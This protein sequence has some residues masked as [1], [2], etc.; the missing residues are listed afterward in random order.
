MAQHTEKLADL[1][2]MGDFDAVVCSHVLE[3]IPQPERAVRQFLPLSDWF[4]IEVPLENTYGLLF[5]SRLPI[6]HQE[7][8]Y[9]VDDET[10]S[11]IADLSFSDATVRIYGVHPAPPVP[12]EVS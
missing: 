3:H 7:V 9:L 12:Q 11:I 6:T 10:P 8:N 2:A 4:V 5:Y 1:S